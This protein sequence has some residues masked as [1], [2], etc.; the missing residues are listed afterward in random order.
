LGSDAASVGS[1]PSYDGR[2]TGT[3]THLI[4]AEILRGGLRRPSPEEII[5]AVAAHPLSMQALTYRL[6]ARQRLT[7]AVGR[8]FRRYA[9]L[10][11]ELLGCEV[12]HELVASRVVVRFDLVWR[13]PNGRIVIDELKTDRRHM[14]TRALREKLELY[15]LAALDLYGADF[16]RIRVLL[17]RGA[18]G[19]RGGSFQL[20][21]DGS[22]TPLGDADG[23]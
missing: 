6:A 18:P 14:R 2:R 8:Y 9:P 10:D 23:C 4:I 20:K 13:M 17:L 11:W 16:D 1:S 15:R 19:G 5:E 3:G 12:R 21:A 22:I 7:L